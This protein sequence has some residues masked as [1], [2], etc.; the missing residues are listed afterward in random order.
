MR[1]LDVIKTTQQQLR[2]SEQFI[3]RLTSKTEMVKTDHESTPVTGY[4]DEQ[5]TSLEDENII[6]FHLKYLSRDALE[7]SPFSPCMSNIPKSVTPREDIRVAIR[8][9]FNALLWKD[10]A[11]RNY[12]VPWKSLAKNLLKT[13]RRF[14]NWPDE[15]EFQQVFNDVGTLKKSDGTELLLQVAIEEWTYGMFFHIIELVF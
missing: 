10:A 9:H 15:L 3:C 12:R 6:S 8:E 2:C 5:T 14:I 13:G 11:S 4:L 1:L 7:Y